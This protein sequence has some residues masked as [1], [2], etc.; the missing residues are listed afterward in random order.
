MGR[1]FHKTKGAISVFLVLVLLPVLLFGGLTTDA[2]RIYFSKVVISDAGE[3]T[4]NAALAQYN[5]E[6]LDEYGLLVMESDP[7][8]Y[9]EKLREFFRKS[10]NANNL[11]NEEEY[12][13]LLDL[14]AEDVH[15]YKVKGSEIYRSEVERQQIVEYMKYRAPLCLVDLILEKLDAM[16]DTKKKSE[17]VMAQM[18]FSQSMKLCQD[19]IEEAYTALRQ[20][21]ISNEEF[22]RT[23]SGS[24]EPLPLDYI[25]TN[26]LE[27]AMYYYQTELAKTHLMI[28]AGNWYAKYPVDKTMEEMANGL[29]AA[30]EGGDINE[31]N[32]SGSFNAYLK[33]IYYQ[34]GVTN[35]GGIDKLVDD[36][37][38]ANPEPTENET[39]PESERK[40]GSTETT[41][42]TAAHA[43]WKKNLE[44]MEKIR[45][46]YNKA[47]KVLSDYGDKLEEYAKDII[48]T[49]SG[50]LTS[51]SEKAEHVD[52][53]AN[54][55][56][57]ELEELKPLI[58]DAQE[59]W[60]TWSDKEREAFPE[61]EKKSADDF[62]NFFT[63]EDA[64]KYEALVQKVQ[65][66][67][68]FYEKLVPKMAEEAFCMKSLSTDSFDDQYTAQHEK[69]EKILMNETITDNFIP[70]SEAY[71]TAF[72]GVYNHVRLSDSVPPWKEYVDDDFYKKLADYR[73]NDGEAGSGEKEEANNRLSNSANAGAEAASEEGYP[74]FNWDS[75]ENA[76]AVLPS[77]IQRAAAQEGDPSM[78][79]VGGSIDDDE[80]TLKKFMSS[81]SA[82][83]SFLDGLDKIFGE[84][85]EDLYIAEYTMRMFSFYTVDI[86]DGVKKNPADVITLSGYEMNSDTRKAYKAEAEYILWGNAESQ[87]NVQAVVMTLFGIRLLFNSI[88]A[89]TDSEIRATASV[90]ATAIC[91]LTPFLKP[92]VMVLIQLGFAAVE[93]A[94]DIKLLKQGY[95]VAIIKDKSSWRTLP[96]ISR[97]DNGNM[98]GATLSYEEYMR[99]FLVLQMLV[100]GDKDILARIADCIQINSKYD[101]LTGY[102]MVSVEAN[103]KSRTSFMRTISDMDEVNGLW[104]YPDDYYD[105]KYQ[106]I[107]GY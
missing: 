87:K 62:K 81:I 23:Y 43:E 38:A 37:K 9:E 32:L 71:M 15:A 3:M 93:T 107:L 80:G 103:V 106:S 55:A 31:E 51:C 20:L 29:I 66:V 53:A 99:I 33:C 22:R 45:D 30:I 102:T 13:Q 67:Q 40:P 59:K 47:V 64:T 94:E 12:S 39:I 58:E 16:K 84:A 14:V 48:T 6:L 75:V 25:Q 34:K 83:T 69:A 104:S 76:D 2:A 100:R 60:Q 52:S 92:I 82:A 65:G 72:K 19:A 97:N 35:A 90:A 78:T 1:F 89:F 105:I 18:E 11:P 27:A 17:A 63:K 70:V 96:Y 49:Y 86:K 56:M 85:L 44:K 28:V 91:G 101:L 21:E 24:Q 98:K 50:Q 8:A 68:D 46:D 26:C 42:E 88:F 57:K 36:W 54:T 95:G 61:M 74:D 4:M 10:I 5:E 79:G 7:E 77:R 41:R 73:K